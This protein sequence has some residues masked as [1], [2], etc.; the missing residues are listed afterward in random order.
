MLLH[1]TT[2]QFFGLSRIIV[3][4]ISLCK[5]TSFQADWKREQRRKM[6]FDMMNAHKHQQ[7]WSLV[8][9]HLALI[10][11]CSL[12]RGF[13]YKRSVIWWVPQAIAVNF[14]ILAS[15]CCWIWHCTFCV[16]QCL[17]HRWAQVLAWR[18]EN[19]VITFKYQKRDFC[20]CMSNCHFRSNVIAEG[21]IAGLI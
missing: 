7:L 17:S 20:P 15:T 12:L 4:F 19:I 10:W 21:V 14:H 5:V 16:A 3:S 18:R 11:H 2:N 13:S 8:M 1:K 6:F 9:K